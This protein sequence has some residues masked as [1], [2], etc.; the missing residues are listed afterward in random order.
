LAGQVTEQATPIRA[1]RST[2][3]L[4]SEILLTTEMAIGALL[5]SSLN[6]EV[7][8]GIGVPSASWQRLQPAGE[9]FS[10][11]VPS[12]GKQITNSIPFGDQ[13]IEVNYY[14]SRD[15]RVVYSLMWTTGPTNSETDS[16]AINGTLSGFVK[17]VAAGYET[18]GG[19]F[20][21]DPRADRDISLSGY[22]GREFDL[23]ACTIPAM[24]RVYTKVVGSQRHMYVAAVFYGKDEKNVSK[25]QESFTI[26]SGNNKTRPERG[27]R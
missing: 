27:I 12:D 8:R 17:G 23:K 15:G 25:F 26:N 5:A 10:V 4:T 14:T 9:N 3:G 21:C 24:V 6:S 18:A 2:A 7:N 13:M 1:G 11:L 20:S 19:K 22:S 16:A